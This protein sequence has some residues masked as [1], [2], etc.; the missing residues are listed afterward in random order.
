MSELRPTPA[1][2]ALLRDIAFSVWTCP[3]EAHGSRTD[4]NGRPVVTVEWDGNLAQCTAPGCL[5]TS[6]DESGCNCELYDCD[7][8][9]CGVGNC[10]C[11]PTD[12]DEGTSR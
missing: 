5:R 4:A 9:C 11:S 6:E 10:T 8:G 3:V 1:R 12:A 2:L 7:G